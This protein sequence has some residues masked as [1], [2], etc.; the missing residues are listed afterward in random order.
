MYGRVWAS[1]DDEA[2][3]YA[4]KI[5]DHHNTAEARRLAPRSRR[6]EVEA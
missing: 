4:R 1:S 2:A 3:A 5:L 6:R